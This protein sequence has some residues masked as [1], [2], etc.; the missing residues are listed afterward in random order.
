MKDPLFS[1]IVS[2]KIYFSEVVDEE[3]NIF[4]LNNSKRDSQKNY[5]GRIQI[6]YFIKVSMG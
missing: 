3:V 4:I 6:N 2:T 5:S 1:K